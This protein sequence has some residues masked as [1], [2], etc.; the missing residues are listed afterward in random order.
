MLATSTIIPFLLAPNKVLCCQLTIH[1]MHFQQALSAA[2]SPY[3]IHNIIYGALPLRD[4]IIRSFV[5]W[6]KTYCCICTVVYIQARFLAGCIWTHLTKLLYCNDLKW[7]AIH[8]Y[9]HG[10]AYIF[11]MS[12]YSLYSQLHS[13]NYVSCYVA[14]CSIFYYC[15]TSYT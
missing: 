8:I 9:V 6:Q 3:S 11:I 14:T 10:M 4:I 7:L 15:C 13:S 1:V 2:E 12:I 5:T